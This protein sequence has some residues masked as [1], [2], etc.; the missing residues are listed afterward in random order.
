MKHLQIF[1]KKI[2][3]IAYLQA[4]IYKNKKQIW[5]VNYLHNI[6]KD[7]FF[8]AVSHDI[9]WFVYVY[10]SISQLFHQDQHGQ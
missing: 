10:S 2:V 4:Y 6:Y 9:V 3:E 7:H 5:S 8:A 1:K